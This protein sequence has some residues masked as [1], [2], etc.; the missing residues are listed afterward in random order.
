MD[1]SARSAREKGDRALGFVAKRI[2]PGECT[3]IYGAG[4]SG[5]STIAM[6]SAILAA[7]E[8]HSVLYAFSGPA[9]F[10][11]R[12]EELSTNSPEHLN[13]INFAKFESLLE[14]LEIPLLLLASRA[15]LL[16]VDSATSAYRAAIADGKKPRSAGRA[17]A[18]VISL[19]RAADPSL[20]ILLTAEVQTKPDG[21]ER[22][23]AEA[24]LDYW[25]TR[26]IHL[27]RQA[28][29]RRIAILDGEP[30]EFRI[31]KDGTDGP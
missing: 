10:L 28:D 2:V 18:Q 4:A 5:K 25:C 11:A 13:R 20:G 16:V 9:S 30:L 31:G 1:K 23:V 14:M 24:T 12:F 29:G 17:L 6:E 7:S 19:C 15:D 21:S 26:K 27:V 3:L 8:G 22:P